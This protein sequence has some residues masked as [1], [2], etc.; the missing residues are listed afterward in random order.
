M[1]RMYLSHMECE[2]PAVRKDGCV[3][4]RVDHPQLSFSVRTLCVNDRG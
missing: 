4:G 1:W 2:D 3:G